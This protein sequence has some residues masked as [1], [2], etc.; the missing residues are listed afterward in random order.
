M[1]VDPA[2]I[3]WVLLA[4]FACVVSPFTLWDF[5]CYLDRIG[6]ETAAP[7]RRTFVFST[8]A[9]AFALILFAPKA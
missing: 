5:V 9:I 6:R 8:F 3:F 2:N 1:I 4:V 7:L